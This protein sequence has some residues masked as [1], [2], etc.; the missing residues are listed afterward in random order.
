MACGPVQFL[1]V[2]EEKRFFYLAYVHDIGASRMKSA[3]RGG[4]EQIGRL[5]GY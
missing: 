5:T 2:L 1:S 4:I 3:S